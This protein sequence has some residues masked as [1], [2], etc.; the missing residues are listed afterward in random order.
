LQ[1]R[2]IRSAIDA[3]FSAAYNFAVAAHRVTIGPEWQDEATMR[4]PKILAFMNKVTCSVHPEYTRRPLDDKLMSLGRIEVSA[5]GRTYTDE[6]TFAYGTPRE[7]FE[8]DDA[9]LIAKF[10]HNAERV[11]TTAQIDAAI[12]VLMN[13]QDVPHI[14]QLMEQITR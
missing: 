11:L 14:S 3:Q 9:A 10:A 1:N 5:N 7:G 6:T 8:I 12:D 4:D 2:T 13:L